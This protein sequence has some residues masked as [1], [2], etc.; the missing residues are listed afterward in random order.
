M[1]EGRGSHRLDVVGGDEATALEESPHTRGAQ[2]GG[3]TAWGYTQADSGGRA[4]RPADVDE[5]G[6][7]CGSHF[8][9]RGGLAGRVE[10]SGTGDRADPGLHQRA[11]VEASLVAGDDVD[12][13]LA[14]G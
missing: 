2:Q 1:R 4:G 13:G 8:H 9:A 11:G 10:V 14:R 6:H 5:V 12:F 7:D 3:R